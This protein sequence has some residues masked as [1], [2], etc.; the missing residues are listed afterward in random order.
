LGMWRNQMILDEVLGLPRSGV[1]ILTVGDD[2]IVNY[3]TSM[4][5]ELLRLYTEFGGQ[6]GLTLRV[7]STGSDLETLK[8]HTEYY[9][10]MY[11]KHIYKRKALV[12]RVRVVPSSGFKMMDVRLVSARGE[13]R[14]V[15]RFKTAREASDFIDMY[16]GEDN[17][18][19]L[20][21]YSVNADTKA[22]LLDMQTELLDI[23]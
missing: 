13:E 3:T 21:V 18:F 9:R 20:P 12:Y 4:G 11:S 5:A 1:V 7:E 8:L 2:V 23:K 10:N 15:G 17:P 19:R 16:Y 22:F 14:V 6:S